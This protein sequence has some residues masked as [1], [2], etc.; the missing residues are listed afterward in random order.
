[1]IMTLVMGFMVWIDGEPT[2]V[3]GESLENAKTLAL[4]SVS[5]ENC[6]EIK[7]AYGLVATWRYNNETKQFDE[8][9]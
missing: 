3:V 6:V 2:R 5:G 7:N 4:Q 9:P 8:I 1:M